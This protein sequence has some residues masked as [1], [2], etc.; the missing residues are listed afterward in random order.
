M[1]EKMII[2]FDL[3]N[4]LIQAKT[5]HNKAFSKAFEKN[6]LK[7]SNIKKLEAEYGK[8][9]KEVIKS[10]FPQLNKKEIKKV[11]DD[12]AFYVKKYVKK[13]VK[14]IPY[15]KNTLKKIKKMDVK[16][17]ITS[18]SRHAS[19]EA[20]LKGAN[21]DMKMF[22]LIIGGDEIKNPKPAPDQ[23]LKVKNKLKIKKAFMIGDTTYD[24]IAAQKAN[25]KSIII[26][27]YSTQNLKT[28]KK[29]KPDYIVKEIKDIIKIITKNQ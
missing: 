29:T 25:F 16:M 6:N 13:H 4:T 27:K 5:I 23:L 12:H 15:A 7:L 10:L 11:I 18:N 20:I 22:D 8:P 2:C 1:N 3:D 17:C 24:A 26:T 28:I 9:G 21:I 14:K 19:I